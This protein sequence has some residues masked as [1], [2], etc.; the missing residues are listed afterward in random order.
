MTDIVE[1]GGEEDPMGF[2]D[3][4][5]AAKARGDS[6]GGVIECGIMG[7]PAGS[8]GDAYFDGLEGYIS[9][10]VFGIPGVKGIEFGSGFRGAKMLGSMNNDPF[11]IDEE[12][13]VMTSSNNHGGILGGIASGMPIVFRAAIKPTPSIA[14]EQETVSLSRRENTALK[15]TGRHDPCI[16]PRAL[17]VVTAAV[18]LVLLDFLEPQHA[19]AET[20]HAPDNPSAQESA[21]SHPAR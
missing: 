7:V 6:V 4:V 3:M 21:T 1:I 2:L 16:V 15:I 5:D 13:K 11:V 17:P 18:A 14:R 19:A 9:R 20:E 10:A 12:G 8:C